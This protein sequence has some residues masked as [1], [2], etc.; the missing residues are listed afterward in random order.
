MSDSLIIEQATR[1]VG[2][3]IDDYD[4]LKEEFLALNLEETLSTGKPGDSLMA[5][6]TLTALNNIK[7]QT[8]SAFT[9][10]ESMRMA[11]KDRDRLDE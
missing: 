2:Q 8:Q 10:L 11:V 4:R 5:A 9:F 3:I 1:L 6:M 7:Y